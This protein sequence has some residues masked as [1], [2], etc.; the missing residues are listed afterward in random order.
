MN[1]GEPAWGYCSKKHR[2][3]S[4]GFHHSESALLSLLEDDVPTL[5]ERHA[6]CASRPLEVSDNTAGALGGGMF[7]GDCYES[8]QRSG[9]CSILSSQANRLS[10]M[11][12]RE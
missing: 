4:S 3:P 8:S 10:A 6:G 7:I 5:L 9:I 2:L 11:Q 1:S 12:V